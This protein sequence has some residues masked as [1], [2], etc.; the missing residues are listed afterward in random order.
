[1]ARRGFILSPTEAKGVSL[2]DV[3][4]SKK[5][6]QLSTLSLLGQAIVELSRGE[7][8]TAVLLA[9]AAALSVKSSVGGLVAQL[10]IRLYKRRR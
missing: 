5:A 10:A 4:S 8:R 3:L 2:T 1:V 7:N 6:Q 9:G